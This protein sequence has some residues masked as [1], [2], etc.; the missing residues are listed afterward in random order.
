MELAQKGSTY[1]LYLRAL[2]EARQYW[3]FLFFILLTGLIAT[4]LALLLPLPLKIIVDSV[5]GSAPLPQFLS[6]VLPASVQSNH[7]TIFFVAIG[8]AVL[9]SVLHAIHGVVD[10]LLR[11]YAAEKMV[12]DFRGKL[13]LHSMQISEHEHRNDG[14]D[15]A[16]RINMDAPSLQWTAL[17]G[18][19]P[20]IV[21]ITS[22]TGMLYVTFRINP[23]LALVALA[24]AIPAILLIHYNQRRMRNK[25]HGVKEME[26]RAQSVIREALGAVRVV[27]VFGQERREQMRFLS[28]AI[29]GLSAKL[30]VVRLES[31]Y[32][33][34]LGLAIAFG[35]TAILYLGVRDVQAQMLTVGELLLIM[36]YIAQLYAPLQQIGGHITSQQRAIASAERSFDLLDTPHAIAERPAAQSLVRARGEFQL[37][38]VAFTYPGGRQVFANVNLD[39][40]AGSCVGIVGTTGAG[41]ST[42]A[43]LL[44]RLFDPTEGTVLLDGVDVRDYRL[45]DLRDQFAVVTQDSVVFSGTIAENI[46]YGKQ[47]ATREEIVAAAKLANAHEFISALPHG[48]DSNVGERGGNLSGGERQ[49]L[50]LAR[51]F[52]KDAPVLILDE[53]T[54]AV[55]VHTEAGIVESIERLM[56]GRTTFM[57]AH[58]LST[59]RNAD[60]ILTVTNGTIVQRI[61]DRNGE[62]LLKVAS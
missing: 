6:T 29:Q 33:T 42:L 16:Y 12:M 48:Y 11:E 40:P 54:S 47:H 53:P 61:N 62:Q 15:P 59:L 41:K 30:R 27:T 19:I 20:I 44:M 14:Q 55:D 57:I 58:R 7:E 2:T 24:T 26:S 43:S 32:S 37:N 4:P 13:F 34:V 35:T 51:A 31:L 25:W 23:K 3:P 52:L 38:H 50:C 17:Y 21:S 1:G 49:R 10:W 36:A 5:L 45:R 8:L 28:H 9:V 39:I 56:R 18:I 46:A 22:L 60:I